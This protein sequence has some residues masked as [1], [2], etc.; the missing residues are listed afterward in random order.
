MTMLS[1]EELRVKEAEAELERTIA[2]A[3]Q[4]FSADT[5]T[6]VISVSI[7]PLIALGEPVAAGYRV[8]VSRGFDYEVIRGFDHEVEEW[9]GACSPLMSSGPFTDSA[10]RSTTPQG[11]CCSMSQ[12]ATRKQARWS[13]PMTLG[14]PVR[15]YESC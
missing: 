11:V 4:Q 6:T 5:G 7:E 3:L 12:P 10:P 13:G 14:L 15:G 8:E 2:L 1:A 9:L